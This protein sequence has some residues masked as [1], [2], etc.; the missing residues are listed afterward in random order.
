MVVGRRG[1]TDRTSKFVDTILTWPLTDEQS[2]IGSCSARQ[3][4]EVFG[5]AIFAKYWSIFL[6]WAVVSFPSSYCTAIFVY[7]QLEFFFLV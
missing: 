7:L 3:I 2:L 4:R 5:G 6:P 1:D